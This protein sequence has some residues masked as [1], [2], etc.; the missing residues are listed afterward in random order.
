VSQLRVSSRCLVIARM[1]T[2]SQTRVA[3]HRA[4]A[5]LRPMDTNISQVFLIVV[6][7]LKLTLSSGYTSDGG[8]SETQVL[9]IYVADIAL[10]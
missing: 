8:V 1:L 7:L 2:C 4:L 9:L 5:V 6:I 3:T 10:H